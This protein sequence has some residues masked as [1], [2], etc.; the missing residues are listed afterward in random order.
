MKT[1]FKKSLLISVITLLS[2]FSFYGVSLANNWPNNNQD[3][4]TMVGPPPLDGS[5][6][7]E[8]VIFLAEPQTIYV[9]QSVTFDASFYDEDGDLSHSL[10][11]VGEGEPIIDDFGGEAS[12]ADVNHTYI[13][14]TVGVYEAGVRVEDSEGYEDSSE[15]VI[16]TVEEM[17]IVVEQFSVGSPVINGK[18]A[19]FFVHVSGIPEEDVE[20]WS[21]SL[22]A[23][24]GNTV[25]YYFEE[26]EAY[27]YYEVEGGISYLFP[28]IGFYPG[29]MLK[30]YNPDGELEAEAGPLDVEVVSSGFEV[31]KMYRNNGYAGAINYMDIRGLNPYRDYAIHF[32]GGGGEADAVVERTYSVQDFKRFKFIIPD[33][34]AGDY[35]VTVRY[36]GE[37]SAP[38]NYH[39]NGPKIYML[40]PR[41]KG[42][43]DDDLR[44][45][46][47]GLGKNPRVL[48]R[49]P[50]V[51]VGGV[52]L[53]HV[54]T[55]G[56]PTRWKV[57]C[58]VPDMALGE[59]DVVVV[60]SAGESDA[61]SYTIG[62]VELLV[63]EI[64][65]VR[66]WTVRDGRQGYKTFF[67]VMGHNLKGG[68]VSIEGYGD[69]LPRYNSGTYLWS[70]LS[71]K[72]SKG[73]HKLIFTSNPHGTIEKEFTVR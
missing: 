49:N 21:Y 23:G 28:G 31:I 27:D 53:F 35:D 47:L 67:G 64:T 17:P 72:L 40:Y 48:F 8:V 13:Y 6:N 66:T 2:V 42:M 11:E 18:H 63:P 37:E 43:P 69:V 29:N 19:Q 52:P 57:D 65:H 54:I 10:L 9:G 62:G 22:E 25:T 60:T 45:T 14:N 56:E 12:E 50:R 20:S 15:S 59:Y 51:L 7:P 24:D 5:N 3:N 41:D 68:Q 33:F 46:A 38:L 16:I 44:V 4:G 61:W 58:K 73:E 39:I 70:Y 71:P 26:M 32:S 36:M 30:I 1:V 34:P 55:C